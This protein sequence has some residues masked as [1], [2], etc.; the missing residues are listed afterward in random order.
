M[1]NEKFTAWK[2]LHEIAMNHYVGGEMSK[3][4]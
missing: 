3:P 4:L 1:D 2:Y